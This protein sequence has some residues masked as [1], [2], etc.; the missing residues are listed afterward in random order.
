MYTDFYRTILGAVIVALRKK[1]T[2]ARLM[3]RDLSNEQGLRSEGE[4]VR[5]T[6]VKR[7]TV[8]DVQPNVL[9]QG[10]LVKPTTTTENLTLDTWRE[11]EFDMTDREAQAIGSRAYG[12][13]VETYAQAIADDMERNIYSAAVFGCSH[14]IA[15]AGKAMAADDIVDIRRAMV[16]R[17]A[18]TMAPCALLNEFSHA[19]LLKDPDFTRADYRGSAGERSSLDGNLGRKFGFDF[20]ESTN[21]PT[22]TAVAGTARVSADAAA[23]QRIVAFD[24]AGAAGIPAGAVF[25]IANETYSVEDGFTG[26]AG[27]V[28][29][30][31]DLAAPIANDAN[32]TFTGAHR[33]DIYID[34]MAIAVAYRPTMLPI[35]SGGTFGSISDPETGFVLSLETIRLRSAIRW[36]FSYLM[37]TKNVW[38]DKT[39]RVTSNLS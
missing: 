28:T 20:F 15:K 31:R 6:H 9:E 16:T 39:Q 4:T 30:N 2:I 21:I 8:R 22:V 27:N 19:A 3:L 12:P 17:D 34:P 10:G 24:G 11:V 5:I 32:P 18:L 36:R 1:A 35:P 7:P 26:A 25:T 13:I 37:G 33:N 29:V 38:Q 14:V 23:N